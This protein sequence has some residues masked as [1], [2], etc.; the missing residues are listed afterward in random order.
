MNSTAATISAQRVPQ[1][2]LT[3]LAV[4]INDEHRQAEAALNTGLQHARHAGELLLQAKKLCQHGEWLPWLK[5]NFEGS[6]RTARA[7]MLVSQRWPQI[8]AKWQ[9][10]ANLSLRQAVRLT[11]PG[12]STSPS[13]SMPVEADYANFWDYYLAYMKAWWDDLQRRR[14]TF[15]KRWMDAR[16]RQIKAY[17]RVEE[18]VTDHEPHSLVRRR[19]RIE[20]EISEWHHVADTVVDMTRKRLA[21]LQA[22]EAAQ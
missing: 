3:D 16:Q 17:T 4:Q 10:V 5:Q 6:A 20:R 13:A 2:S 8:E 15:Q 12:A 18:C 9:R 7:Y 19:H 21:E 14:G 11:V 22:H 1:D